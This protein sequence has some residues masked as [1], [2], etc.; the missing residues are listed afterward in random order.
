MK[1]KFLAATAMIMAL[2]ISN[3]NAQVVS[4]ASTRHN[5][6]KHGV[7]SGKLTKAEAAHLRNDQKDLR[8]HIKDAKKDGKIT[9]KE[10]KQI[11]HDR[12]H[13]NRESFHKK[14]NGRVRH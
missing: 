13:L 1:I 8:Q 14:H 9:R 11:R 2:S 7:K 5:H 12:K 6:I 4:N 10:R 3:T